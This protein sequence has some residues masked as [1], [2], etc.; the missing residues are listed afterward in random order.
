MNSY[1]HP[2]NK[3]FKFFNFSYFYLANKIITYNLKLRFNH[4]QG[5]FSCNS[6]STISLMRSLVSGSTYT[7]TDRDTQRGFFTPGKMKEQKIVESKL[8]CRFKSICK[9]GESLRTNL[10]N[11]TISFFYKSIKLHCL[12][13]A[14][15]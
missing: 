2:I 11:R 15:L 1:F 5:S 8:N 7:H 9:I 14:T 4:F 12:K 3:Q 13:N 10:T 6:D